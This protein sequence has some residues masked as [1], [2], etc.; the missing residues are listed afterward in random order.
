MDNF[1]IVFE[2]MVDHLIGDTGK[3]A[4]LNNQRDGKLIDHIYLDRSLIGKNSNIYYIGDSKYY[5]NDSSVEGVPL[6]KQFTYAR[7]AIQYN[8][9][10][11]Y[12][13][14]KDNPNG[15]RYRDSETEG[16][17]VTPNFFIRPKLESDSLDFDTP[18]FSVSEDQPKPNKHFE[19]RLFD[20]DTLLLRE[21]KIN[22]IFIIA[23]YGAYEDHWAISLRRS[24]REDMIDFLNKTYNFFRIEPMDIPMYS[25]NGQVGSWPFTKYFHTQITGKVYK[26]SED[27]QE[28]ILAFEKDTPQGIAD[29]AE[30]RKDIKYAIKS[31]SIDEPEKLKE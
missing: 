10:E 29:Y 3:L 11:Y 5:D 18:S 6:Y 14:H 25:M 12:F 31:G 27:S 7:N 21:Y 28:L 23:A 19:D 16:Y 20:R 30:V 26:E 2:K 1:E 24:I 9:D 22:L 17:N 8:I 4:S 15:I 13:K